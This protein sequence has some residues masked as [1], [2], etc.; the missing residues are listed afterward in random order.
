MKSDQS[1]ASAERLPNPLPG[2]PRRPTTPTILLCGPPTK[3]GLHGD[4]GGGNETGGGDV[5][6]IDVV[7]HRRVKS[8]ELFLG[9]AVQGLYAKLKTSTGETADKKDY[10]IPDESQT[11]N[12]HHGGTGTNR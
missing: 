1:N 3:R 5:Q 2:K 10:G 6:M 4:A 12:Q 9:Y 8:V 11:S 7:D